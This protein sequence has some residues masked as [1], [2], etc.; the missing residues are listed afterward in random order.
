M[1]I[2]TGNN[3]ETGDV[4]W[5]SGSGWSRHVADAV[6]VEEGEGPD[7]AAGIMHRE[8]ASRAVNGA[9]EIEAEEGPDGPVP[10][11]MKER[12]RAKGPSVR[13]DLGVQAG[14]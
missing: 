8:M 2:L 11:H 7:C 10:S 13:P 4:V 6:F 14:G 3:L 1:I 12:M 9:Y 5:W